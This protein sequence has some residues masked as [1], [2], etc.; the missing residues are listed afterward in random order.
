VR[1]YGVRMPYMCSIWRHRKGVSRVG[2]GEGNKGG[3]REGRDRGEGGGM[4]RGGG[5]GLGEG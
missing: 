3:G 2:Q 4:G 1:I 5:G